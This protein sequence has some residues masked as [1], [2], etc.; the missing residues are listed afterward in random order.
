[1]SKLD[2]LDLELEG[3]AYSYPNK[4]WFDDG[5]GVDQIKEFTRKY[6]DLG[7][8]EEREALKKVVDGMKKVSSYGERTRMSDFSCGSEEGHNQAL[9]DLL[10]ELK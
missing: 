1:M 2:E 5:I 6:Y 10:N 4:P 9:S 8:L 7:K 3:M